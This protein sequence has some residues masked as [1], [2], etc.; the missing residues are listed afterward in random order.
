MKRKA[1]RPSNRRDKSLRSLECACVNWQEENKKGKKKKV[2]FK[3]IYPV[4]NGGGEG[5]KVS[6]RIN[7]P[8][9]LP[10]KFLNTTSTPGERIFDSP[11]GLIGLTINRRL[12]NA[13][14]HETRKN[15]FRNSIARH[16]A[17]RWHNSMIYDWSARTFFSFPFF[18]FFLFVCSDGINEEETRA[19]MRQLTSP[20]ARASCIQVNVTRNKFECWINVN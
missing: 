5:G 11:N 15:C 19:C 7:V 4:I 13:R 17:T 10:S 16:E 9:C 12:S 8:S 18:F 1:R 14:E 2:G 20:R 6:I 3:L